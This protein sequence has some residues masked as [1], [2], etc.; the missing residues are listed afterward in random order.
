[1][2]DRRQ[3][4]K[5]LRA[6]KRESERKAERRKEMSRR[7]V[8]AF[9][10]GVVVVGGIIVLSLFSDRGDVATAYETFRSQPTACGGTQPP[11]VERMTFEAPEQ[12][13]DIT[14]ASKVTATI[15]T[16]CGDLII[17]L[18]PASYPQT[19]NSFVFL[20]REGFYDGVPIH[21]INP[22]LVIQGGDPLADGTGG[23]GYTIRDERPPTD[24]V[25]EP[26]V[27]AMANRGSQTTGSQFFIV[28]HEN[29]RLLTRT[30]N[31]LGRLVGGQDVIDRMLEIERV[32]PP[33]NAEESF[34]L[35]TVYIES[36]EITVE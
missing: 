8:T 5:E 26:G 1:M 29:G 18:D 16:S 30:F 31:G 19:V 25:Y 36:I 12:Q 2:T 17:E 23:P 32:A 9:V 15:T 3:R 28:V 4:Q 21:R 20:A 6:Q 11:P 13:T 24:F 14:E 22:D 27:V 7:I 33:G 35:E 10:F 34:P